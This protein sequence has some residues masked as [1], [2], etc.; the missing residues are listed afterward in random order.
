M[1]WKGFWRGKCVLP[2]ADWKYYIHIRALRC[3]FRR[4]RLRP[5]RITVC[6]RDCH[7][8]HGQVATCPYGIDNIHIYICLHSLTE[9]AIR[10]AIL[11]FQYI[12]D[13]TTFKKLSN[14]CLSKKPKK[15]HHV[16]PSVFFISSCAT[17]NSKLKKLNL[18]CIQQPLHHIYIIR[19]IVQSWRLRNAWRDCF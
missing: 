10:K 5:V 17:N 19:I 11:L 6:H 15:I 12:S 18:H 3:L 7:T 14:L 2:I 1:R 9:K 4:D 13:L 8:R 16:F